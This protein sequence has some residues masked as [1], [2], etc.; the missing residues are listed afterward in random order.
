MSCCVLFMNHLCCHLSVFCRLRLAAV[1][2]HPTTRQPKALT[3]THEATFKS[4]FQRPRNLHGPQQDAELSQQQWLSVSVICGGETMQE[5]QEN[6]S[7]LLFVCLTVFANRGRAVMQK[8]KKQNPCTEVTL[9]N[10]CSR[11]PHCTTE[12]AR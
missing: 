5:V 12:V 3:Q 9:A 10:G 1:S 2:H 8:N 7:D 4:A 11:G 6:T